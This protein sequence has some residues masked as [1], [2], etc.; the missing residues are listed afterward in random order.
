ML[1]FNSPVSKLT[2]PRR[3]LPAAAA[4][5][6]AGTA[7][8]PPVRPTLLEHINLNIPN[9]ATARAFYRTSEVFL[10]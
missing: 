10:L 4:A 6:A 7:E 1:F 5:V 2:R 9:E 8:H 3:M